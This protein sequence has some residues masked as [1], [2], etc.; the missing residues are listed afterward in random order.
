M[1][2]AESGLEEVFD[3]VFFDAGEEGE[4]FDGD[5]FVFGFAEGVADLLHELAGGAATTAGDVF[6]ISCVEYNPGG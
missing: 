6:Y 4:F 1:T 2:Q 5:E 3:E